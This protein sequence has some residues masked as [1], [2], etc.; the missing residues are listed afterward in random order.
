[1]LFSM[2]QTVSRTKTEPLPGKTQLNGKD[3]KSMTKY[4][5]TVVGNRIIELKES[6]MTHDS[7]QANGK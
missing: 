3:R 5:R 7:L 1:M 6:Q 4:E 2:A